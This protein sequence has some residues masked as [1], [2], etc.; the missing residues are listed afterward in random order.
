MITA[1]LRTV[2]LYIV[3]ITGLRLT[4]KRQIGELEPNELVLTMLLSDLAAVPMQDF[5][6][7]LIN[8]VLPIITI[9]CLSMLLSYVSLRSVRFRTL[10]CGEPAV[11]IRSGK[12]QQEA[13][14][15]NRLTL[16]ELLEELRCQGVTDLESVKYAILETSGQISLL[17]RS[18]HQPLTARQTGTEVTD[19]VFLPTILINDGRVLHGAL[20][21]VGRDE[22]WL[23]KQLHAEGLSSPAQVFL[24]TLDESGKCVCIKKEERK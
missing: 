9:L 17:L 15:H 14:R 6:I 20:R 1:L 11:L 3:L 13:M 24:L 23:E 16:D 19:D 4:G 2:I 21:T 7:P 22:R 5:G 10:V 18:D 8:G 12:I